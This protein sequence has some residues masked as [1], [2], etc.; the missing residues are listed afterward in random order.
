MLM[1]IEVS[2]DNDIVLEMPNVGE[3]L[4]VVPDVMEIACCTMVGSPV[5]D[6]GNVTIEF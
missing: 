5:A 1:G 4:S 6:D 2:H 3:E